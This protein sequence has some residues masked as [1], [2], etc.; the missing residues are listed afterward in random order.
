MYLLEYLKPIVITGIAGVVSLVAGMTVS[1]W[2]VIILVGTAVISYLWYNVELPD[3]SANQPTYDPEFVRDRTAQ[4]SEPGPNVKA[5]RE[6]R[7]HIGN[8]QSQSV[9]PQSSTPSASDGD[10]YTSDD[11]RDSDPAS[12]PLS[13]LE[14]QWT[15]EIDVS[16]E[17][18]G[19]MANIKQELQR[20]VIRPL[21]THREQ[22]ARLG[23]SAASVI[24][25][26]PPELV[27]RILRKPLL[28]SLVSRL[29]YSAGPIFSQ[30]GSTSPHRR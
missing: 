1:I 14:Y 21:T 4:W 9:A 17:D 30:N 20:D 2:L 6:L 25:Y 18:V 3:P 10:E 23:V 13:E 26:G 11:D 28:L 24:F 7:P 5:R 27:K 8:R 19:G 29:P 15:T 16:F 12:L 22:A